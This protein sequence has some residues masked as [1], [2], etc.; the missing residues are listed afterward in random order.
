MSTPELAIG[1]AAALDLQG[2]RGAR[3]LAPENTLA[4]FEAGLRE[5][6]TTLELDVFLTADKVLVVHHDPALNADIARGPDGNWL[7]ARGPLIK[8]LTFAQLQAYDVGRLKDGSETAKAFP[9]QKPADGQ[10]VPTLAAVFELVKANGTRSTRVNIEVKNNPYRAQE[11]DE[12][13]ELVKAVLSEV[14]RARMAERVAI[15]SFNWAVMRCAQRLAPHI[16][17]GYLTMHGDRGPSARP[18]VQDDRWTAGLNIADFGNSVP[19]LVKAAGGS[20]WTPNFND[21]TQESLKEAKG[22]GL[23][24]IPWTVN[25]IEDIRRILS[26]RVDGIITDYPDRLRSDGEAVSAAP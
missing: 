15:Q 8:A 2:H 7:N 5:G 26:W 11:Y 9:A 6:A 19:R 16:A 10:R 1:H 24:V 4:G 21:L 14:D 18:S 12:V 25:E 3:G 22:L 13:E 23:K 17:T 20:I